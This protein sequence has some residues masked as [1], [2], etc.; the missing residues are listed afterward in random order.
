MAVKVAEHIPVTPETGSF[1]RRAPVQP[2]PRVVFFL[3]FENVEIDW[4]RQYN[5]SVPV[6]V[7]LLSGW[8][9]RGLAKPCAVTSLFYREQD[10]I[11]VKKREKWRF[12]KDESVL[13]NVIRSVL[14]L[15]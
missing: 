12:I 2:W 10:R 6:T 11:L 8:G 1:T 7:S 4:E 5:D 13:I 3:L 14:C 15:E 9:D